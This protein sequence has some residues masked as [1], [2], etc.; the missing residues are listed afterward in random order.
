[1]DIHILLN[2]FSE[3][4]EYDSYMD[5][6]ATRARLSSPEFSSASVV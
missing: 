4:Q 6:S 5:I 1:M 2:I 3:M